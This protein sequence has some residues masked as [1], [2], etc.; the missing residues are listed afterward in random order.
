MRKLFSIDHIQRISFRNDINGL[1]AIAVI[2]VILYHLDFKYFKGGYLGVDIFFVISGYLISNI[3]FS[4][5]NNEKFSLLGFYKR[6]IRRILPAVL[7]II[8]ATFPFAYYL[9]TPKPMLEYLKSSVYTLLFTSNYYFS[10]LDFY[11]SEP[12]NYMPFL[13]T[14]SL[15]IEEQFYI[16]FPIVCFFIYK[17]LRTH[18]FLVF[19]SIS[20]VSLIINIGAGHLK[21]YLIQYRVW[22]LLAGVLACIFINSINIKYTDIFGLIIIFYSFFSFGDNYILEIE[23]RIFVT[24]GVLLILISSKKQSLLEKISTNAIIQ[25]IGKTSFSLYLIHQ[26]LFAF[27]RIFLER[28][29]LYLQN[30]EINPN[31]LYDEFYKKYLPFVV[32]SLFVLSNLNYIYVEKKFLDK[33]QTIKI[34][35]PVFLL[36]LIITS[37]GIQD[38][39][40]KFRYLDSPE[41][42]EYQTNRSNQLFLDGEICWERNI[43][44]ICKFD[45]SSN[46]TIY[47]FGDSFANTLSL[48]L[49]SNQTSYGYNFENITSSCFKYLNRKEATTSCNLLDIDFD[50]YDAYLMSIENGDFVYFVDSIYELNKLGADSFKT[51]VRDTIISLTERNN[52]VF[53]IY[54]PPRFEYS[55]P[56]YF[57]VNNI[58]I[59]SRVTFPYSTYKNDAKV[60][61]IFS[62]YDSIKSPLVER[63]YPD[64]LFC[65]NI[66]IDNCVGAYDGTLFYYD[67][68]HL[69]KDGALIVGNEILKL[70]DK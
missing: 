17:Y 56:E 35:F 62:I 10:S 51:N 13:H 48:F 27:F 5:L 22:Q 44:N 64:R 40:F 54:P 52:R 14:W 31:F 42:I 67:N 47:N 41:L 70:I 30:V 33:T 6:R 21:F 29:N 25:N 1:R 28:N 53:L 26:P 50:A 61:L 49:N 63:I 16:I 45:T 59:N 11:N 4:D 43:D 38:D 8:I 9:L 58:D 36:L 66:I 23:P 69:S 18:I 55:I 7:S 15:G 57:I 34:L 68:S 2:G 3:I 46:R 20:T 24:F 19:W 32:V 37:I 39:G 12:S 65:Q 60:S